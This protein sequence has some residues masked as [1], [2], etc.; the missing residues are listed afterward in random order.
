MGSMFPNVEVKHV[1]K[2]QALAFSPLPPPEATRIK[3]SSD[4]SLLQNLD[5]QP[6]Y[7]LFFIS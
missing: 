1:L 4:L 7:T 2:N 5:S 6:S 3:N